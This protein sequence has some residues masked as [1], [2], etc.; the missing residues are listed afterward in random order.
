MFYRF[1]MKNEKSADLGVEKSQRKAINL[2]STENLL[3][4]SS[5]VET[6]R[7]IDI[8]YSGITIESDCQDTH[9]Q[10]ADVAIIICRFRHR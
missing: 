10:I 1:V 8:G 2:V 6:G 4:L 3:C 7:L 5:T 9:Y